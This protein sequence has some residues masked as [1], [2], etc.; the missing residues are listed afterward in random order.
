MSRHSPVKDPAA[1]LKDLVV[2]KGTSEQY[3]CV[4]RGANLTWNPHEH[5]H[6]DTH[7]DTM[8]L[9]QEMAAEDTEY[10]KMVA[11]LSHGDTVTYAYK[12]KEYF[13]LQGVMAYVRKNPQEGFYVTVVLPMI[14]VAKFGLDVEIFSHLTLLWAKIAGSENPILRVFIDY[15]FLRWE[16]ME[17]ENLLYTEYESN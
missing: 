5:A 7:H 17:E 9:A 6:S 8:S 3:A 2:N 12:F 16:D 4:F 11:F 10:Q 13:G 14:N 15:S 1:F